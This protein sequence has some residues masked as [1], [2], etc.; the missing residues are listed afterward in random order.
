[1]HA[2]LGL[3]LAWTAP[4]IPAVLLIAFGF[5]SLGMASPAT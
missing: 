1:M 3:N 5:A 4:A 2:G